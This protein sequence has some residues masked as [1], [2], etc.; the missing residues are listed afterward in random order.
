MKFKFTIAQRLWN[1]ITRA[2]RKVQRSM[3]KMADEMRL[4]L[5]TIDMMVVIR[6][7]EKFAVANILPQIRPIP[8]QLYDFALLYLDL[9]NS[10]F[11]AGFYI[12]Q[13]PEIGNLQSIAQSAVLV[14]VEGEFI[15]NVRYLAVDVFA[16]VAG[17]KTVPAKRLTIF[18]TFHKT[19]DTYVIGGTHA[20]GKAFVVAID[21]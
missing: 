14:S 21:L 18:E 3:I 20:D 4:S 13:L 11:A 2:Q 16:A 6:E 15:Q 5:L 1:R 8:G 19:N 17:P 10:T 9:P 12:L 7:N